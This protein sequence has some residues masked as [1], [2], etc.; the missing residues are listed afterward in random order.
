MSLFGHFVLTPNSPEARRH[1]NQANILSGEDLF[2]GTAVAIKM[3]KN[4][5]RVPN[6]AFQTELAAMQRLKGKK[7]ICQAVGAQVSPSFSSIAMPIYDCDLFQY[8]FEER[9]SL[10]EP[11]VLRLFKK[12]CVGVY[13]MHNAGVAHLDLKPENIL[14]NRKSEELV[15]CDFGLSYVPERKERRRRSVR[16][17]PRG[18]EE[19]LPP[20]SHLGPYCPFAADIYSLGCL[21][22]VLLTGCF[23]SFSESRQFIIPASIRLSNTCRSLL[24]S[25]LQ[26]DPEKRP[27][28][29]EILVSSCLSNTLTA[30]LIRFCKNSRNIIKRI[31]S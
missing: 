25:L 1:G 10:G 27:E 8:A 4:K 3:Y 19:Y 31:S 17:T 28:I 20:E 23:P 29:E 13:N 9:R 21:L 15:I 24:D 22:Y 2:S 6:K 16:V 30:N 11:E 18:T 14:I 7:N 26:E 5:N 12:I